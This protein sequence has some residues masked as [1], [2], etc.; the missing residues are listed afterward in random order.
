MVPFF[1]APIT[2]SEKGLFDLPEATN[3][4][5]HSYGKIPAVTTSIPVYLY[6]LSV[7]D[8]PTSQ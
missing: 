3:A 5:A 1:F 8:L 6:R 7:T 4:Y 2:G